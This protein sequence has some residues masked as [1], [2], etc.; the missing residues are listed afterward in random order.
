MQRVESAIADGETLDTRS[1]EAE[2]VGHLLTRRKMWIGGLAVFGS[3]GYLVSTALGGSTVYYLTV[4]ELRSLPASRRSE[5]LRVAGHVA[6]GTI[7]RP[8]SGEVIRFAITDQPGEG[9]LLPVVYDGLVPDVFNEHIE[10]VVQGQYTG[11][12]FEATMLL[13]KCPS[14]FEASAASQ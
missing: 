10:V 3:V 8:G 1:A 5:P 2:G 7:V 13:A 9:Q 11:E 12:Q 4:P 14:K 6:P